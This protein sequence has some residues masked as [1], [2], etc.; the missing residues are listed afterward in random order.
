V[1]E[2][3]ISLIG[4]AANAVKHEIIPYFDSV[5][6]PLQAYLTAQH[7]EETQVSVFSDHSLLRL[8]VRTPPG[9]PHGPA[10]RGN[11]GI[12]IQRSSP[13]S[14]P[15]T[16]PSRPTSRPSTQRKLR[17]PYSEIIPYFDS[18]YGPLQ[19]Y[20]TAQHTEETQVS[21]FIDHSLLR[22]RVR[23]PPDLP[24]SPAH[25]GNSFNRFYSKNLSCGSGSRR[26]KNCPQ[27][28]KK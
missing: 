22:L 27:K 17:Y 3:G 1:R 26:T 11:S 15:C 12:L 8:R 14:T 2:L 25:R 28:L 13:T 4:S 9:L 16:D 6:G 5:Y 20:L 10:H 21:V 19:A 18:V 23:T 7:T 24:H